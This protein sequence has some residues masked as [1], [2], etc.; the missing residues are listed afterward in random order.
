MQ[1]QAP[2]LPRLLTMAG[3]ALS[4]FG[5]L[6][7]LWLAFGGPTPLKP[8]GYRFTTSFNEATQLAQ[9]ADV[10]ISGVPIGKV[11][12]VQSLAGATQATIQL[13]QKY[14]PLPS[15]ARAVLRQKTLLG[16]T[17]VELTPGTKSARPLK[18]GDVLP[19]SQ[20]SPTVEL[21]EIFRSFDEKTRTA[22]QVWMQSLAQG[23][24]GR[25]QDLSDAFGNLQPFAQDADRLL[26]VLASQQGALQRLVR[27]TGEVFAALT[28]RDGQLRSLIENS[29]TVF[30]TTAQRDRALRE[31]FL[32][33]PTFEKESKATVERLATFARRTDPLV[34][35]LRPVARELSPTLREADALAP[36]LSGLLRNLGPLIDASKTGLP[37]FQRFIDDV[38]PLFGQ[39][40]PFLRS[41]N[42]ILEG[43]GLY[44]REVVAFFA[45]AVAATGASDQ[46]GGAAKRIHYLRTT[47]PVNP[48]VLAVYPKRV[49]TNRTNPYQLP[50]A[51][52]DLATGLKSFET[53]HCANGT[54]TIDPARSPYLSDDLRKLI[55]AFVFGG[56]TAAAPPCVKQGNAPSLGATKELT[57]FPHIYQDAKP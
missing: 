56:G 23:F 32:A 17:Y 35:D 40:D 36:R 43:L 34:K 22:F 13:D 19:A 45:N 38:R 14:A 5:L 2:T 41:L 52:A 49:G 1:K 42:P 31:T 46:P 7:F 50:G 26:T 28:E 55:N 30:R 18:E 44:R 20:V 37:A 3:F 10:T 25:G 47:Q 53:R 9:E 57:E 12:K 24:G 54:P 16:E 6:L 4:C 8:K 11:K 39:L 15:D 48:E 33:L 51:F 21:D 27:N 29:N